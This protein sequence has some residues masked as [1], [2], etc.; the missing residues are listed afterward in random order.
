M[1]KK[2]K[3]QRKGSKN[4]SF[5]HGY[6][7]ALY[8]KILWG[9]GI[10]ILALVG[11]CYWHTPSHDVPLIEGP[12]YPR[13]T[14]GLVSKKTIYAVYDRL[15]QASEHNN[16]TRAP[17]LL[18]PDEIP[19]WKDVHEPK[20]STVIVSPIVEKPPVSI[21]SKGSSDPTRG[22]F[23]TQ[24]I[25]QAPLLGA[26]KSPELTAS[27]A[28]VLV[29]SEKGSP[30]G[31]S[32]GVVGQKKPREAS[33]SSFKPPSVLL[34]QGNK[35]AILRPLGQKPPSPALSLPKS[36]AGGKAVRMQIGGFY[37]SADQTQRLIKGLNQRGLIP[38][39][40]HFLVQ[41][42]HIQGRTVYR[43]ILSGR[44]SAKTL[45]LVQHALRQKGP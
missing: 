4:F 28:K 20:V 8:P 17:R 26:T 2:K 21:P 5:M 15:A 23:P 9:C 43:V 18:P 19:D 25:R 24:G 29:K 32:P 39:G 7:S 10:F 22:A 44:C 31:V 6:L 45:T 11:Y 30:V 27:H 40:M 37:S 35:S 1:A 16:P 34:P 14:P 12:N 3:A 41:K 42:A 33:V 38:Q 36:E 13:R